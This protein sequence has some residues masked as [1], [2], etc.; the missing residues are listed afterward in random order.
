MNCLCLGV[1]GSSRGLCRIGGCTRAWRKVAAKS[2]KP[3][4]T[5]VSTAA[6]KSALNRVW[7]FRRFEKIE[8]LA[9]EILVLCIIFTRLV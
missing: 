5:G 9:G 3:R 2:R 7:S 8:C 6:S 4:G 1:K